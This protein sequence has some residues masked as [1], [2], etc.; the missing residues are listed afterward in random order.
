MG[1]ILF[2]TLTYF[3]GFFSG[4]FVYRNNAKKSKAAADA[5]LAKAEEAA[6]QAK[7]EIAKMKG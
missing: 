6:R 2:F 1:D 3:V 5:L 7:I 4:I